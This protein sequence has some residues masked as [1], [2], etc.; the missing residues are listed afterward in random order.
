[1]GE[2]LC[3][4]RSGGKGY[5]AGRHGKA[6]SL[7]NAHPGRPSLKRMKHVTI[8]LAA[9]MMAGCAGG[10]DWLKPRDS[11]PDQADAPAAAAPNAPGT[12]AAVR[13]PRTARTVDEFDTSSAAE[14]AAAQEPA[15]GGRD[16]GLTIASLGAAGEPG[17][18]LKT[19]LVTAPGPGRAVYPANGKSVKVDLIPLDGAPGAGSRMSLA[20]LRVLDAPLTGLPELQIYSLE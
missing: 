8:L 18:W 4:R 15:A 11:Q 16:L 6:A 1:M 7:L 5:G 9:T 17:F 10:P 20:A 2:N 12:A 13:P 19:P 3:F 14:K